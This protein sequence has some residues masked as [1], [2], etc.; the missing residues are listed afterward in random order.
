[1][2]SVIWMLFVGGSSERLMNPS[3]PTFAPRRVVITGLGVATALGFELEEFWQRLL[4]GECGIR[5]LP[6][7]PDDSPLPAKIAGC[8]DDATLAAAMSR[9]NLDDPD[10]ANQLDRK[11]VV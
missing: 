7:L 2:G 11:S 6:G 10:R 1:M 3:L 9:W 4:G 8:L 5:R